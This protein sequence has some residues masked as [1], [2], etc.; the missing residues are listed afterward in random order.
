[1]RVAIVFDMEGVS[2]IG[3]FRETIPQYSE[4]WRTGRAKLTA[5]IAAA[6][7]GLLDADVDDVPIVN[8]HGAGESPWPNLIEDL[9]PAGAH[10][11]ECEMEDLRDIADAM[12]QVGAHARGGSASF[13]S[14]TFLPGFRARIADELLSESHEWA[15]SAKV[16]L[17]GIVGSEALGRERGPSLAEVPFLA[18]QTGENRETARPVFAT[19]DESASAI[20]D[21]AGESLR[22]V[23]RAVTPSPSG[24]AVRVS[25]HNADDVGS[26][27]VED[28]WLRI[29][30]TEFERSDPTWDETDTHLWDAVGFAY[31][32]LEW[33]FPQ[34][35]WTEEVAAALDPE[36]SDRVDRMLRSW[37]S[38]P[39]PEWYE[40]ESVFGLEG[41]PAAI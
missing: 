40:P 35:T 28:G 16:P 18:V 25:L 2:H 3:N 30:K 13:M 41:F 4:Y 26:E 33:A 29:S 31:R 38:S 36:F 24:S 21:F 34:M 22:H 39:F 15:F 9:L 11:V 20:Q 8:H 14:H 10:S 1:M 7:R 37:V 32:P 12:L 17:I 5:D 19:E 27:M 23:D 6:A